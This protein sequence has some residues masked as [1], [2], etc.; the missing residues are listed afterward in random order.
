MK[1]VYFVGENSMSR[2]AVIVLE[3][4]NDFITGDLKTK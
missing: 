3:I 2:M 4:L 1:E